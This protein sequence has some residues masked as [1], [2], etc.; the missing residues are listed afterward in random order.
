MTGNELARILG[1]EPALERGFEQVAGLRDN[2]QHQREQ[3]D[4]EQSVQRRRNCATTI[5]ATT[6]ATVPP[7]APDQVFFGL[8]RGTSLGPPTARPTK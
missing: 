8:T 2:R 6:A 7:I 3:G 1:A 4:R 5:A